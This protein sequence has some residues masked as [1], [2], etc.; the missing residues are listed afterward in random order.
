MAQQQQE[1]GDTFT[2]VMG[3]IVLFRNGE[4]SYAPAL[5]SYVNPDGSVNLTIFERNGHQSGAVGIQQ[6]DEV[7]QWTPPGVEHRKPHPPLSAGKDV[8]SKDSNA[9]KK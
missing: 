7:G 2:V 8:V 9:E 3:R 4:D 6:G 1:K 5:I